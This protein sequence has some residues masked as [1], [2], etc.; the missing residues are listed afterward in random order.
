MEDSSVPEADV[1]MPTLGADEFM[2]FDLWAERSWGAAQA[3]VE[4]A[5][6]SGE[7]A[8]E[9]AMDSRV[10]A[11]MNAARVAQDFAAMTNPRMAGGMQHGTA[12]PDYC[13]HDVMHM[14]LGDEDTD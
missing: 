9:P 2:R 7:G 3:A 13:A 5:I 1:V 11:L 12:E 4:I 8:F 6:D 10:I 14:L